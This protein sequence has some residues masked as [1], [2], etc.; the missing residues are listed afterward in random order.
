MYTLYIANKNYSSWSLRPWVLM[1]EKAI[2]FTEQLIPFPENSSWDTFR[3]FAPNGKVPCLHHDDSIVWD[4]LAIVEYLA[5]HHSGIWPA[6]PIARAWARS[7][8]AEMHSGFNTIRQE[9]GMNCGLRIQLHQTISALQTDLDR[10]NEILPPNRSIWCPGLDWLWLYSCRCFLLSDRF[11]RPNLQSPLTR[12]LYPATPRPQIDAGMGSRRAPRNLARSRTRARKSSGWGG[13]ARSK[14]IDSRWS[15]SSG[16]W[17]RSVTSNSQFQIFW[18]FSHDNRL[19]LVGLG[20]FVRYL[21]VQIWT[22]QHKPAPTTYT[23]QF[24]FG[25]ADLWRLIL[26]WLTN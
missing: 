21:M 25:I 1:Q 19:L 4:S 14:T 12:S 18:R 8:T 16:L 20:G 13:I 5:E 7:V 22:D 24:E 10:L 3:N 11:P 26:I 2:A 15:I 17:V 23:N 9:C 6:D